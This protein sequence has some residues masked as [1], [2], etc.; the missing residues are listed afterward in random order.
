[1]HRGMSAFTCGYHSHTHLSVYVSNVLHV[2]L[3]YLQT[4]IPF[5]VFELFSIATNDRHNNKDFIFTHH[6]FSE[7]GGDKNIMIIVFG[8][9][10]KSKK[11]FILHFRTKII[12][13]RKIIFAASNSI[14]DD[15]VWLQSCEKRFTNKEKMGCCRSSVDSSAPSNL[16]P[17]VQIPST[18]PTFL[19][20][21]IWSGTCR[22]D[23]N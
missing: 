8:G 5:C 16:P 17:R 2:V 20:N 1:M 7:V 13:C 12:F 21:F 22:K 19:S 23:E 9:L 10:E 6:L 14:D 4:I 11:S 3:S 15:D 18:Q